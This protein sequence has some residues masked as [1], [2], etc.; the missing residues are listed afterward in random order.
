MAGSCGYLL[1]ALYLVYDA[2]FT[3]PASRWLNPVRTALMPCVRAPFSQLNF[4]W[5]AHQ[6]L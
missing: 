1:I 4:E 2:D 6:C 5:A 3:A